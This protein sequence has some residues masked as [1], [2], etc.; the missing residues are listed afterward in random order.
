MDA[1]DGR[2]MFEAAE[3]G[4]KLSKEDY[5]DQARA[6]RPRL[7]NAQFDLQSADFSVL[8]L[9]SGDDRPGASEVLNHLHE[10]MDARYI[11][12]HAFGPRSEAEER[13]P[14]FWRYWSRL[15]PSGRIGIFL[16]GWAQHPLAGR[17]DG[18]LDEA[19]YERRVLRF[20][21]LERDLVDD[22]VVLVKLWIHLSG[23]EH[24]KR[25][26][27]ARKGKGRNHWRI[28]EIDWKIGD[29]YDELAPIAE[30]LLRRT[31]S[32]QA[33]WHVIEGGD[34]RHR[35]VAVAR[36]VLEAIE[37]RLAAAP[38]Q[39]PAAEPAA[40]V[41]AQEVGASL[42]DKVDLTQHLPYEEY[43]PRLEALQSELFTLM[44]EAQRAKLRTV[45]V[46]EGWDA[47]GKGGVIRRITHPLD[48]RDYRVIPIGA[49]TEEERARHYLWRFWR[50]IPWAGR[51]VIFDRS[52]YGR[53]L[54][55]RIEG[56]ASLT[57]WRRAYSE[58]ND[59]EE[60]LV[61]A[62]SVLLKFWLHIDPEEQL[63][64]FQAREKTPYKKYKITDEDYRNRER[65]GEY[66][67]AVHDMVQRTHS[68]GAPWHLVPANDK[69]F[70][71][72]QVL[73]TLCEALSRGLGASRTGG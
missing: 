2:S 53:V 37:G 60:Q 63:R 45:L 4:A 66:V 21:S 9:I 56:F 27:K 43:K 8:I 13:R 55:E 49:P 71:R 33:P 12:T 14:R 39:P 38:E 29:H 1:S 15:P 69:R 54:V 17:L 62:D 40:P 22:G 23:K 32:A 52:W 31:D 34:A 72:V 57:E 7:L 70:A 36:L 42:L 64:R 20:Q 11:E 35:D 51:A 44:S 3:M 28:D 30:D 59:F 65:W 50:Q 61:E 48:A 46:F 73:D 58:I 26:A 25:L 6:L 18:R 19:G 10:W 67:A 5:A 41:A 47:A 68:P 24:E 16:G